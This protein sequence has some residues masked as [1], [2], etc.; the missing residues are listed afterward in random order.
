MHS[1]QQIAGKYPFWVSFLICAAHPHTL[2]D[3]CSITGTDAY[4]YLPAFLGLAAFWWPSHWVSFKPRGDTAKCNQVYLL[5]PIG[6]KLA[7]LLDIFWECLACGYPGPLPTS[8]I[9]FGIMQSLNLGCSLGKFYFSKKKMPKSPPYLCSSRCIFH[10]ILQV[11]HKGS[12]WGRRKGRRFLMLPVS[13]LQ[14]NSVRN[15]VGS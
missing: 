1:T 11:S 6:Q 12:K 7:K 9:H 14:W 3:P 15:L 5:T 2:P 8:Y 10:H 4:T 13:C